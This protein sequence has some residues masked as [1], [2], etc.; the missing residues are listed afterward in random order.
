M[1][2]KTAKDKSK[3]IDNSYSNKAKEFI[4]NIGDWQLKK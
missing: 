4:C 2:Q 1:E 3:F